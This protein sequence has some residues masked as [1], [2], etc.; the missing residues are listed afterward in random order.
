MFVSLRQKVD[1]G[2]GGGRGEMSILKE[3]V[4]IHF[5]SSLVG[6][7]LPGPNKIAFQF[8]SFYLFSHIKS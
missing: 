5:L 6:A 3:W 7:E 2:G 4:L 8:H 1:V